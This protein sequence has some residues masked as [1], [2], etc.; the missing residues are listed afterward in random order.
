MVSK[1]KLE[2]MYF[3]NMK[4][5]ILSNCEAAKSTISSNT[6]NISLKRKYEQLFDYYNKKCIEKNQ[7]K[8]II[9]DKDIEVLK[10]L[11][12]QLHTRYISMGN[13]VVIV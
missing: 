5:A 11:N 9:E 6:M 2:G 7:L 12:K 1:L 13:I 3:S 8:Y 4:E 10:S